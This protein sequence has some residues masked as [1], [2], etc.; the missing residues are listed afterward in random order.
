MSDNGAQS[1]K[2]KQMSMMMMI[3]L[4]SPAHQGHMYEACGQQMVL[5]IQVNI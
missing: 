3:V 1:L 2:T 5:E 4:P